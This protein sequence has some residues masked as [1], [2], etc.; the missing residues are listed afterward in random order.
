MPRGGA[1]VNSGPLPKPDGARRRTNAGPAMMVLPREGYQGEIPAWPVGKAT[2][3]AAA[4]WESLW[5]KPQ[6][7]AWVDLGFEHVVARLAVLL[8]VSLKPSALPAQLT[9]LRQLEDRLGLNPAAM[10]RLRWQIAAAPQAPEQSP[11]GV[12]S[13]DAKRASRPAAVD[14]GSQ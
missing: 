10:Q 14:D 11:A 7:A 5:R 13:L 2:K 4:M 9:E 6:A 1:R 12:A 3:A 8:V